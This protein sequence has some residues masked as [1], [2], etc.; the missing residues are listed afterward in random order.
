[1][2][3]LNGNGHQYVP[4]SKA[5]KLFNVTASYVEQLA[6]KQKRVK[7]QKDHSGYWVYSVED[8]N[9]FFKKD[10]DEQQPQATITT[11]NAADYERQVKVKV[12]LDLGLDGSIDPT[13]ALQRIRDTL[14]F[15][16]GSK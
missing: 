13:V 10:A 7:R 12:L 11:V 4:V 14:G 16:E 6:R 1:M 2:S 9:R 8:L 3:Y 15:S 5:A